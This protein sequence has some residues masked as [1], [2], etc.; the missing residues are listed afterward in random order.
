MTR[1]RFD[2]SEKLDKFFAIE[3]AGIDCEPKCPKCFCRN[4]PE[5]VHNMKEERE[6]ALF[7]KV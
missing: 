7:E 4:C 3:D 6:L 5:S 2:L 1:T